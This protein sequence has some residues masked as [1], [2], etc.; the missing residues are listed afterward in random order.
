[1]QA[2]AGYTS[3]SC[4]YKHGE[5]VLIETIKK[6]AQDFVGANNVPLLVPNGQFGTRADG[7]TESSGAARYL[8]TRLSPVARPAEPS[9]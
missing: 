2:L 8:Y 3:D 9:P 1:M 4:D 5:G 7:G 6:M